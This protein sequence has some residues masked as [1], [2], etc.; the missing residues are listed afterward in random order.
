MIQR[1]QSIWLLLAGITICCLLFIPMVTA[2]FGGMD[3]Q[4]IASGLYQKT[5]MQTK[6]IE[7]FMPL[8]IST[9]AVAIMCFVNI[10]NFKNRTTQKRISIA[11]VVLIIGLS[12]WCSQYAKKIPG[13]LETANYSAG[14]FLP[15]IAIF[16]IIL[17]I[18][19]INNDDKLIRSADRLR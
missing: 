18:R 8:F 11:S 6:Q 3:Y 2:N 12:F 16:F 9:I 4:I 10:F 19:G 17:A 7:S 5:G 15:V 1:I 14:M 13:G